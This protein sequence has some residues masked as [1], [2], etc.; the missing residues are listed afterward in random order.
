M[1]IVSASGAR[2]M[3]RIARIAACAVSQL[4]SP[5]AVAETAAIRDVLVLPPSSSL[6]P[7]ADV[8]FDDL[9]GE[10]VRLWIDHPQAGERWSRR[11]QHQL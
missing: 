4:P 1:G 10:T 9:I 11:F 7:E 2:T 6:H 5:V 8:D 3:T